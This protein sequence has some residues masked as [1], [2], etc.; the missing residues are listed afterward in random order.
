MRRYVFPIL[1]GAALVLGCQQEPP[2]PEAASPPAVVEQPATPP[3]VAAETFA[4]TSAE[5]TSAAL[6]VDDI[7]RIHLAELLELRD[8]GEVF[9]IDVRSPQY[10]VEG[11]IPGAVNIPAGKVREMIDMVPKGK[12][13]VTYCT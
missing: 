13:I 1:L 5:S 6:T 2:E 12:K 10:Y 9:I 7:E 3:P 8:A 11:H 4:E